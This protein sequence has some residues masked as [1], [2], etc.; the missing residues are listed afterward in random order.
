MFVATLQADT[1]VSGWR[2][3][4]RRLLQA[5]VPP[6][7][8]HWQVGHPGVAASLFD[9]TPLAPPAPTEAPP[10]R[11][12]PAFIALAEDALLHEHPQRFALAY[13]L[14]WRLVHEP[15][16]RGDPLDADWVQLQALAK[17]VRRDEHK[18]HAFVRFH[19][20]PTSD[21][22]Q[23]V[24]WF[25]PQHHIVPRVAGFFQ[26]RFASMR[27]AIFTPRASIA[28]DGQRLHEGAGARR[29]DV[30]LHDDKQALWLTYYAHIF[31]PARLKLGHMAAEMPRKYWHNLPEA[32]LIAPLTAQAAARMDRMVAQPPTT[33]RKRR[34]ALPVVALPAQDARAQA[35]GCK[36]CPHAAQA[37]QLV[38]GEGPPQAALMLV[39]E[40]PGDQEDLQGRPFIGPAGALLDRALQEAG[41]DRRTTYLTNAVKHF[42][43]ELRGR[44]RL[45]KTP[46]QREVTACQQ[47]LAHEIAQVAPQRIVALGATAA[48]ALLGDRQPLHT[49][50]GR[51]H[52]RPDGRPV[53]VTWHPAALLRMPPEQ[54]ADAC[55]QWV[56]DLA[57]AQ[58]PP[59]A[60]PPGTHLAGPAA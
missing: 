8:V 54:Q 37:T 16:V 21:G 14:L 53:L 39:G 29:D 43:F 27:W 56:Q 48:Q 23:F 59:P 52:A 2:Q 10:M 19:E 55:L 13:R 4:A 38:W 7:A 25:E 51:W 28:W 11:V 17:A 26:R 22:P 12:P 9:A 5:D 47:W 35:S 60:E 6:E 46:G 45:H 15:G 31:N 32:R 40:Q 33:P 42:R 18:M 36:L 41:L 3:Q 20:R 1:D 58:R 57:Q 50:R 49:L 34:P 30:P 44:R 24:A